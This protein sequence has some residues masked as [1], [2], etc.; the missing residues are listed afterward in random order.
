MKISMK[1]IILLFAVFIMAN[2]VMAASHLISA[3]LSRG[4]NGDFSCS[5]VNISKKDMLFEIMIMTGPGSGFSAHGTVVPGG[6]LT[7]SSVG[8]SPPTTTYCEVQ[9]Y[10]DR[11]TLTTRT[12]LCTFSVID[13]NGTPQISVPVETRMR[14]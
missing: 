14:Q 13:S 10:G 3:P 12:V 6:M 1:Y 2:P 5:C 11:V 4:D 8:G 9:P 7:S